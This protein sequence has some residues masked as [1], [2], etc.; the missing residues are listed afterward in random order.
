MHITHKQQLQTLR[1]ITGG[2]RASRVILTANNYAMFEYLKTPTSGDVLAKKINSDL[3]AT[4]ILLDAVTALGFLKKIGLKYKNTAIANRFLIQDS[5]FYQGDMLRHLDTLW[6]NWSGLDVVV[7]TGLPNR[8]GER[9]HEAFIKAMHNNAIFHAKDVIQSV[10]ITG[11][12]KALDLGG[13]PGTYSVELARQGIATTLFDLPN[14]ITIARKMTR[15]SKVKKIDFVSGDFHTDDIGSGY[16][17]VLISQI[18]HSLS[19]SESLA[20]LKKVYIALNAN[21]KVV[22]HEFF[23]GHNRSFPVSGALFTVNM[24]VNTAAGRCYTPQEMKK[25]LVLTG[26]TAINVKNLSDTVVLTGRKD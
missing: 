7:K 24:L 12:H 18:V 26:F 4:E 1:Q 15:Q 25:W 21:G 23:L 11:V 5:P 10:D 8:S 3:R 13:G 17:L 6:K 2:F 14:T 9:H 19:V 16:D 20:L 22:L